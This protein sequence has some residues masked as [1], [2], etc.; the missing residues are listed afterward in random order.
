MSVREP[1]SRRREKRRSDVSPMLLGH[2]GTRT[3]SAAP[4]CV[5]DI[6]PS[7]KEGAIEGHVSRRH[8]PATP[9]VG[10]DRGSGRDIDPGP[11][12]ISLSQGRA[13]DL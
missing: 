2:I 4:R 5:P 13:E 7:Y 10:V 12:D 6:A 11:I 1:L 8:G 9:G 3:R